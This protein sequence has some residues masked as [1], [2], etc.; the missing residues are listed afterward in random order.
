MSRLSSGQQLILATHNPGKVTEFQALLSPY[1]ITVSPASTY[2]I[3]EPEETGETFEAN[4]TLKATAAS[5]ITMLPALADD[6]GLVIPALN[7]APGVLSA[8]WAGPNK[9]FNAA[10]SRIELELEDKGFDPEGIKAYFVCNLCI[11]WPFGLKKNYEGRVYGT[12][13]FPARGE[14]GFGYDPI[15]IPDG[16]SETFGELTPAVKD[17]ISHRADAFKKL[18]ADVMVVKR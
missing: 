3:P 14:H 8:R 15:F 7:G 11:A 5:N 10:I 4:A 1:G 12:L 13:T 18:I 9:D 16:Y 2:N 17:D 6:S